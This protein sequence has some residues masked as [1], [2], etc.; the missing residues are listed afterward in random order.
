[1]YK[2]K[3][4]LAL[5]PA[6]SG[7]KG[8]PDKNIRP[9]LGK[10][11][12]AW[13]VGQ[14][15]RSRYIDRIIVSTDSEKITNISKRYGAQIPFLRPN[16]LAG[17]KTKM[18]DVILHALGRL[19]GNDEIYDLLMLLQPTSPLR[20]AEDIDGAIKLLFRKEASA[21][22]SVCEAEHH[23]LWS[24]MLPRDGCMKN[25]MK[26]DVINK[27][28]QEL[29]RVYRLNGAI[30]LAY[31]DYIRKVKSF[32]GARTF[33]YIMPGQKSVDIDSKID[34]N[35]AEILMKNEKHKN[36]TAPRR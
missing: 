29:S 24:N 19:N 9:F 27:N 4:I 35:L 15:K 22:V 36:H 28:R 13:T 20:T 21:V 30:Y 2:G 3:K 31:C 23:P 32:F 34:F 14:A 7:S 1:M 12:I 11:L 33:A 16:K 18:I 6:R 17:H 5:I 26:L 10:P 8:L 25:F